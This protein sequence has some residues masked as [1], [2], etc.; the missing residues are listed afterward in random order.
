MATFSS[1]QEG[2]V[3]ALS[4]LLFLLFE[5][6]QEFKPDAQAQCSGLT[7]IIRN[8]ALGTILVAR[9]KDT[10]VAMVNLLYTV[11]TALGERVATLEDMVVHHRCRGSGVGSALLRHAIQHCEDRGIKRITLLTDEVNDSAQRFYERVGFRRS[12]M[13]PMRLH[14]P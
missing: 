5:Q 10:V 3:P 12:M 7:T 4:D 13:V 8:P 2:D 14:L 9:D 6:E 11:S 1:A